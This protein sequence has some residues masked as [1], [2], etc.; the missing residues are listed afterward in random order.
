MT[1]ANTAKQEVFDFAEMQK[2]AALARE[3]R[4]GLHLDGARLFLAS[5]YTGISPATCAALFDTVWPRNG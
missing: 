1:G 5:A 2:I 4:I 3:R